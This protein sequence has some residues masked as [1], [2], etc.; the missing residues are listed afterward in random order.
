MMPW[1]E[2]G[3]PQPDQYRHYRHNH[4]PGHGMRNNALFPMTFNEYLT[5]IDIDIVIF[6]SKF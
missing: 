2:P 4:G 1:I 3:Q 5:G 6:E